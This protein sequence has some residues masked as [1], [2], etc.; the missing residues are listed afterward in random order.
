MGTG[1][2]YSQPNAE[3]CLSAVQQ[4]YAQAAQSSEISWATLQQI[5]A[6]CEQVFPGVVPDNGS[7]TTVYDCANSSV[8]VCWT[9][10]GAT[11]DSTGTC[12][13]ANPVTTY[14]A[15]PGDVCE[16]SGYTCT[17]GTPAASCQPGGSNGTPGSLGSACTTNANCSAVAPYCD[18]NVAP[19]AGQGSCETGLFSFKSVDDDCK[20]YGTSG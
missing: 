18:L 11:A 6:A 1:R 14:C 16:Q 12:A 17:P 7:C 5:D 19:S 13:P 4:A 2:G 8:D 9:M 3:P 15:D 20:A 10:P